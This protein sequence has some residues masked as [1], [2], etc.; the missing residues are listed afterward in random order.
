LLLSQP[1]PLQLRARLDA[2]ELMLIFSPE[3]CGEREPL[4]V[5]EQ[6]AGEVDVVQVRPKP[7]A[8]QLTR[9][10]S[11][12]PACEARATYEWALAALD[13]FAGLETAPLLLVNDRV[14]VALAL[15][16]RGCAGVHL[17][18][19]DLPPSAARAVLGEAPLIGLSTHDVRQVVLAAEEPVDY[20]G[21]GPIFTSS[22]KGYAQGLG[23]EV[24]WVASSG[25]EL[26]IFAI[27][28]IHPSN[29]SELEQLGRAAVSSALLAAEDPAAAARALRAGLHGLAPE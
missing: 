29:A 15:R 6:L 11:A 28:G 27:G 23:G 16:E 22:T 14:D 18:Q 9:G 24:C 3:L 17:G 25:S 20:L 19:G 10:I 7:P 2:A 8:E 5:L 1:D 26:P 13:L 4:E 21:L 12:D